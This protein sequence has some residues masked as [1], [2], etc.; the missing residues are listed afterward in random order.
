MDEGEDSGIANEMLSGAGVFFEGS[1]C[2]RPELDDWP[3]L[4]G[5]HRPGSFALANTCNPA[6]HHPRRASRAKHI[7]P[8]DRPARGT[9]SK[10]NFAMRGV[11]FLLHAI[12]LSLLSSLWISFPILQ[13]LVPDRNPRH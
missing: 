2:L 12:D 7:L 9:D 3:E 11:Y 6:P 13:L 4:A 8:L 10:D 1:I 5:G